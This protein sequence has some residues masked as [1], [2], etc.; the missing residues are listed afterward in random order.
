MIELGGGWGGGGG[1]LSLQGELT[2]HSGQDHK[3]DLKTI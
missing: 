2:A 3:R 1:K